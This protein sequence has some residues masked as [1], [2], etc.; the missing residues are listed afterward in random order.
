MQYEPK[1]IHENV[2]VTIVYVTHDQG[3]ALTMSNR[4]AVFNDGAIQQFASPSALYEEPGNAFVAQ[5][6]GENNRL[7]GVVR[8][9]NGAE[10]A[11]EIDGGGE[12]AAAAVN[13]DVAGSRTTLPLRPESV[14]IDPRPRAI[15]I[16]SMRGSRRSSTWA[17]MCGC[18][19]TYA[20]TTTSSSRFRARARRRRWRWGRRGPS[21]G[22]RATAGRWTWP[23]AGTRRV[24]TAASAGGGADAGVFTVDGVPLSI[25]L[26]RAERMRKLRAVGLIAPLFLFLM[27]SFVFPILAMLWRSV[28]NPEIGLVLPRTA[29]LM[30]AWDGEGFPP[31]PWGWSS[32]SSSRRPGNGPSAR[33]RCGSTTTSRATARWR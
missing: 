21:A 31:R 18:A 19:S 9:V 5:F 22:I 30:Q 17:T 15:P 23:E 25:K 1:H 3:E 10:G 12:V 27:V 24:A 4:I 29:A 2:G 13:I 28:E 16:A 6:I 11:V 14:R 20:H 33:P 7:T 26:R 32:R 8:S